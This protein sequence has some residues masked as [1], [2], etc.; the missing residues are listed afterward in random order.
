MTKVEPTASRR[1]VPAARALVPRVTRQRLP[2]RRERG[3]AFGYQRR[4]RRGGRGARRGAD[5]GGRVAHVSHRHQ[6]RCRGLRQQ[7]SE[8]ET[9]AVACSLMRLIC[10]YAAMVWWAVVTLHARVDTLEDFL[11]LLPPRPAF[12]NTAKTQIY[13]SHLSSRLGCRGGLFSGCQY[14]PPSDDLS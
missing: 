1:R 2:D 12:Y 10:A 14:S 11:L 6:A 7:Q 3:I 13:E 4:R 9:C 5:G 8:R